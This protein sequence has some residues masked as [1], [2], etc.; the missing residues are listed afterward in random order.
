M[1]IPDRPFIVVCAVVILAL[2]A[3]AAAQDA[4]A[5]ARALY[6]A[7]RY[8]EALAA[9]NQMRT[10]TTPGDEALA[11]ENYRALCLLALGR[12]GDADAAIAVVVGID[13]L[14]SPD[15]KE[16]A[17][18]VRTFFRAVRQRVLPGVAQAKYAAAK[19]TYD[20]KEYTRAANEFRIVL[21][22][23]DDPDMAGRLADLRLVAEGFGQL[24]AKAALPPDPPE[25]PTPA[26]SPATNAAATPSANPPAALPAGAMPTPAQPD[27]A[28]TAPPAPAEPPVYGAETPTVTP[29]TIIRQVLP[30][31]PRSI[32]SAVRA[33]GLYEITIDEAGRVIQIVIRQSL[34]AGYDRALINAAAGW[35]YQP[36]VLDGQPVRYRKVVQV[37]LAR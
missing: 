5:P 17:P 1:T 16:V 35:Q 26:G 19:A 25:P 2:A 12:E 3:G 11:V 9:L 6:A 32:A 36:A 15:P 30:A 13:P 20:A 21:A 4:L 14:Y 34:H 24:A 28:A 27:G 37:S 8:E 22:L 31:V 18:S 10:D 29:P 33:R 7:A 23:I